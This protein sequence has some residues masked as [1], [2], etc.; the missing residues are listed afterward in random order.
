M[1]RT[2]FLSSPRRP[3]LSVGL[4]LLLLSLIA[5]G[6]RPADGGARS[7]WQASRQT[8]AYDVM[9][10]AAGRFAITPVAPNGP[11]SPSVALG[12]LRVNAYVPRTVSPAPAR[13]LLLLH[14][15]GGDG[16]SFAADV[17]P[18][19]WSQDWIVLA[20]TV[21]YH[22]YLDA[23]E[24]KA[25]DARNLPALAAFANRLPALLDRPVDRHMLLL[26]FSRGGQTAHRF[27]LAYPDDVRAVATLSSG[28]YTLPSVDWPIGSHLPAVV[29]FGVA[30]QAML[31][32]QPFDLVKLRAIPFFIGV[33]ADDNR[34]GDVARAWDRYEGTDRVDRARAF[35]A[36]LAGL[37]VGA[38]L[39]LYPGAVHQVTRPMIDDVLAFLQASSSS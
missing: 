26:G 1:S 37:R 21:I 8:L 14:G 15:M 7:A 16:P 25:D 39:R 34:T 6:M 29:P 9:P 22:G 12:A 20:P 35:A 33:G 19:S 27:A 28:S 2:S 11:G 10:E 18:A 36:V 13:V 38:T 23:A 4:G 24:V 32:G 30:D 5:L 3:A 17:L 31:Y